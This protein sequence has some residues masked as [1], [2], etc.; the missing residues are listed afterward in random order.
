[1]LAPWRTV[2]AARSG[3]WFEAEHVAAIMHVHTL[4]H[5]ADDAPRALQ[6]AESINF[7]RH[8]PPISIMGDK[9]MTCMADIGAALRC[10]GLGILNES[11]F[12][13]ISLIALAVT[14]T[15]IF[16]QSHPTDQSSTAH[17]NMTAQCLPCRI[18]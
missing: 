3:A 7:A 9:W 5:Y 4:V 1:M 8:F 16:D 18:G 17:M 11:V 6:D 14:G 15:L 2:K 12:S 13:G 10:I